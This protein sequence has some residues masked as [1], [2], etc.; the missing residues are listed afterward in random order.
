MD[1]ARVVAGGDDEVVAMM[2]ES[3][4]SDTD[5]KCRK[6]LLVVVKCEKYSF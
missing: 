6:L 1:N 5:A 4:S 3:W 2:M